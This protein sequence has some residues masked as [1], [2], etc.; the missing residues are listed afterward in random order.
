MLTML[1]FSIACTHEWHG[2]IF[3]ILPQQDIPKQGQRLAQILT[4]MPKGKNNVTFC[5]HWAMYLDL[6][7]KYSVTLI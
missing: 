7:D 2:I 4:L 5:K 1:H 3:Q 6:S